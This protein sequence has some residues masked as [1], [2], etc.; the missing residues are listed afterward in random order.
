MQILNCTGCGEYKELTDDVASYTCGSCTCVGAAR[1]QHEE[2]ERLRHYE[3]DQSKAARK[4]KK[5]RQCDLADVLRIPVGH[6]SEFERGAAL[7]DSKHAKWLDK[8]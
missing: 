1:A 8:Q 6:V 3:P 5:W 7:I 2:E 4:A